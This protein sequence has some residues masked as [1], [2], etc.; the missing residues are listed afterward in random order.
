MTAASKFQWRL[1]ILWSLGIG[2]GTGLAIS[3][4]HN[5]FAISFPP[6]LGG[7]ISGIIIVVA[8]I[9]GSRPSTQ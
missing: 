3:A 8:V 5:L 6:I 4:L 9:I 2:T 7:L 1:A